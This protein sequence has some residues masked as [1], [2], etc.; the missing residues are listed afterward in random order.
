MS[1]GSTRK[2][3]RAELEAEL[4]LMSRKV[5]L[6]NESETFAR[7]GHFEWNATRGC[8]QSSSQGFA[9]IFGLAATELQDAR[10]PLAKILPCIHPDDREQYQA[11]YDTPGNGGLDDIEFR[12]QL[13][14]GEVRNL[15][16]IG[17]QPIQSSDGDLILP[18][19]VQDI[20]AQTGVDEDYEY[21]ESA[22]LQAEQVSLIGNFIYDEVE[23]R[24]IYA[25]PGCA[26][27]YGMTEEEYLASV[28]S[29]EDDL[30]DI[31]EADREQVRE[32]YVKYFNT[33]EDCHVEFRA[34][35]ND[36]ELLWIRELMIALKMKDGKVTLTRGVLQDIT[37]QKNIELE[38]RAAK[39]NLEDV[40]EERTRE[41]ANTVTKL[42]A[43]IYEREKMAAELEFLANHDPLTG[44]P[45]LRLCKDRLQRA[46][47]ESRRS[48]QMAVIM[49]LDLD[50]FKSIN[51]NYGH[52]YGD[53][54]LRT[55]ADR[56]K[57]EIRETDTV[58]RIGGD[59]FLV[60]LADIPDLS[61]IERVASNLIQQISQPI[62]I[63]GNEV[64]VGTSIGISIYPDDASDAD[65]LIRIADKAMYVVKSGVKNN[66]GFVRSSRLN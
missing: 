59:E 20:S 22:A 39:N 7:V 58:A 54:V 21:Q 18:G 49:F 34:Y 61:I 2:L 55:T 31:Y 1:D 8:M 47:A 11:L 36:G 12:I 37:E 10:T 19:V 42:K 40:V 60:I 5:A 16:Q 48:R 27:I 52:E 4:A 28:D 35:R 53:S 15:Y 29:V 38:L 13:D 23:D 30:S 41:L 3:S 62:V 66:F 25:S 9:A 6:F 51:D 26:R 14:G 57:A 43:E 50:G 63:D 45:S 32:Q 24:Y 65:A 64:A 56:I 33:G 44:L 17:L 46:L